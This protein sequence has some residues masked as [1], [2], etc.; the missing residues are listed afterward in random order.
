MK[1]FTRLIFIVL[2]CIGLVL[3]T[4]KYNDYERYE[5]AIQY[6]SSDEDFIQMLKDFNRYEESLLYQNNELVY[7]VYPDVLNDFY[8]SFASDIDELVEEGKTVDF[9]VKN[10]DKI[11][12]TD[13]TLVQYSISDTANVQFFFSQVEGNMLSAEAFTNISDVPTKFDGYRAIAMSNVGMQYLF[14]YKN[15]EIIEVR[16]KVVQYN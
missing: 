3:C 13:S 14:I 6:I 12:I 5:A 2:G 7:K 16:K 11:R 1:R 15:Q 8:R 9:D 4:F 10:M